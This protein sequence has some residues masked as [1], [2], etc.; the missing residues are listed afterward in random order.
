MIQ[1]DYNGRAEALKLLL[2]KATAYTA[3]SEKSP[4]EVERKLW[5]WGE[6][7]VD[8]SMVS[9]V[10][11]YLCRERYVDEERYA[12]SYISDK[13]RFLN[14]GPMLLRMELRQKGIPDGVIN[15][16]L[17]EVSREEWLETLNQDL[18]RR[19]EGYRKKSTNTYELRAKLVQAAYRRG[20]GAEYAE[21]VIDQMDLEVTRDEESGDSYQA[22]D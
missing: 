19:L 17:S 8:E 5:Q 9:E 1:E 4:A 7:V 15:K 21:I 11:D 20:F 13:R 16:A 22:G 2:R 12:R 18:S 3:R 14:K 10:M 6:G